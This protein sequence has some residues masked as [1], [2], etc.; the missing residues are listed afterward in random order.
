MNA[1]ILELIH[2]VLACVGLLASGLITVIGLKTQNN[3]L[4][5]EAKL[6]AHQNEVK[7]EL[8]AQNNSL[9]KILSSHT[10]REDA[11]FEFIEKQMQQF[12]E[13][14]KALWDKP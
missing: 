11:R 10:E 13:G 14:I 5:S 3:Q 1:M 7:Q 12:R 8:I 9:D 4:R 2:I 6:L